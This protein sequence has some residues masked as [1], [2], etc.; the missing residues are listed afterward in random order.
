MNRT[1]GP[2]GAAAPR[3]EKIKK[4]I[5]CTYK[6]SIESDKYFRQQNGT[7]IG[8]EIGF[9]HR[10]TTCSKGHVIESHKIGYSVFY[11]VMH[12]MQCGI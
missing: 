10:T 1:P 3:E 2:L 11:T 5:K 12:T 8:P 6:K 9:E 4:I 7:Y